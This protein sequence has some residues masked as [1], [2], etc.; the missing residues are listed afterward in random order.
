MQ[1]CLGW[2]G[3][4][5]K[6]LFSANDEQRRKKNF[7]IVEVEGKAEWRKI[8]TLMKK[9]SKFHFHSDRFKIFFFAPETLLVLSFIKKSP[10]IFSAQS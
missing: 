2:L 9:L 7:L 4:W 5:E 8:A 6:N 10:E 1:I 3:L